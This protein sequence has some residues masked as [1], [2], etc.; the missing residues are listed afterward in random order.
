MESN[1]NIEEHLVDRISSASETRQPQNW[2]QQHDIR[3]QQ[4]MHP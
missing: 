2:D 4:M 3:R 1:Y